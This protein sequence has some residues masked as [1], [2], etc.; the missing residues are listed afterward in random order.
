MPI[1]SV[2]RA[3]QN[4]TQNTHG[5]RDWVRD[6]IIFGQN[7]KKNLMQH[8]VY[9]FYASLCRNAQNPNPNLHVPL[10]NLHARA[11]AWENAD[12]PPKSVDVV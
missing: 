10:P 2:S 11:I 9:L 1:P 8:E 7:K 3:K 5:E 6:E 4:T 12:A